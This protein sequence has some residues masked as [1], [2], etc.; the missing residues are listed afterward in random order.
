MQKRFDVFGVFLVVR[1]DRPMANQIRGRGYSAI[2]RCFVLKAKSNSIEVRRD[3]WEV[4]QRFKHVIL[5][6]ILWLQWNLSIGV[7]G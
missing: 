5:G 4:P 6:V 3:A 2:G 7:R 1:I